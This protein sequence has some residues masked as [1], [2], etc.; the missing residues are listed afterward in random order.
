MNHPSPHQ[1]SVL[2]GAGRDSLRC[3]LLACLLLVLSMVSPVASADDYGDV[4]Q[5]YRATKYSDALKKADQYLEG[6]PRDPQMRFLKGVILSDS[7]KPDEALAMFTKLTE[8]YPELP[9]PYNNLAVIHA[10]RNQYD[11]A[12][13]ALEMAVRTNPGY[14]TA[15][16]NLGDVYV[17]LAGQAYARSQQLDPATRSL[18]P[19]LKLVSDLLSLSGRK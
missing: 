2:R 4:L 10:A 7:G 6:K 16:E 11:K 12:R 18:V 14:A 9:E 15:H 8:D 19:K 17:K 5:L 13:V 1:S 3:T